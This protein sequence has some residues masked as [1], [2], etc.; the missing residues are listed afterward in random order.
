MTE[1][2]ATRPDQSAWDPRKSYDVLKE[3]G[4]LRKDAGFTASRLNRAPLVR[5][6]LGGD[7]ESFEVARERMVSAIQSLRDPYPEI[8]LDVFAVSPETEGVQFLKDRRQHYGVKN[9]VKVE[10]VADREEPALKG[11][12]NQLVTGWY[13]KSPTDFVVPQSHNGF[14]QQS[15]AILTILE[16]RAWK[17]TREYY[18]LIAAFDQADFI[19]ISSSFPSPPITAGDFTVKT[20]RVGASF[21]HRF[22]YKE[23]MRQGEYYDLKFKLVPD[24]ELGTPGALLEESR[25]FHEPTRFAAFQAVFEGERPATIWSYRG[26]T[27][28]E[29][30]ADP[31]RGERLVPGAQG[32]VEAA[33]HDLYG[34]LYSGIAW[35]W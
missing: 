18:R 1:R 11:L 24:P 13:P 32:S 17:E 26:L 27:Y 9:G 21:T 35:E 23:P 2:S 5:Q 8:L 6:L 31:A 30:P 7:N 16:N 15:V 20:V 28:F 34:G 29:R 3:L 10:A 25:A 12:R 22:F 19:A 33:F 4:F 14:I